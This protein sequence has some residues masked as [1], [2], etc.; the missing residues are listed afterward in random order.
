MLLS[1]EQYFHTG[2]DRW[3]EDEKAT[4]RVYL[5]IIDICHG[6]DSYRTLDS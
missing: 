1:S 3:R 2:K 6:I 4:R 5:F